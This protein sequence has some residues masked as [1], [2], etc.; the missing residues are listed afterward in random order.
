MKTVKDSVALVTGA[1]RGIGKSIV[2]EFLQAGA[3]KVYAAARNL[4]SLNPLVSQYGDRVVPIHI[5]LND[6]ATITQAAASA[7]DVDI[8]VNNAG[9]LNTADPL[10]DDAIDAM[11]QEIE[12]NVY[13]TSLFTG[14]EAERRRCTGSAELGG[15][16]EELRGFRDLQRIQGGVL[17]DHAGAA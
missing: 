5:D 14:T 10:A 12:V 6:P 2:E 8:V 4:E 1:N 9:M 17:L 3:A 11:Q 7:T 13:G 15:I 16:D